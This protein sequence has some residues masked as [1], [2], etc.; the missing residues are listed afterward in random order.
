MRKSDRTLI[1]LIIFVLL[2]PAFNRASAENA[3]K[4]LPV[5]CQTGCKSPYGKILGSSPRGIE[6]YSNCQSGCV[7]FEPNQWNGTYTGIKWQCVEY[8][9]RWL[10]VNT[11]TVY[12]DVD[13]A[14]DIWDRID[15]L[16]DVKTKKPIPLETRLNGSTQAPEVGDLLIYAKAF[17][18]TGH[19]AVVTGIDIKNGLIE[20]SEQN[21]NN[22]SWPDDYARKIM[23][24]SKGGNYWLLDGYLL[25]WKHAR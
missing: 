6:A 8:A 14:A 15:H 20:V 1:N 11:G 22:E 5:A 18:G 4:E 9:R 10:L 24:I 7:I 12:G 2:V 21:F 17:N 3:I 25:G 19:V 23:L 16:T 13:I